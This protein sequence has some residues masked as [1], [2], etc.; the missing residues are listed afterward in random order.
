MTTKKIDTKQRAYRFTNIDGQTK[1]F[2]NLSQ[3][4]RELF[5][6]QK[7]QNIYQLLFRNGAEM[8][9]FEN[10]KIEVIDLDTLFHKNDGEV[11]YAK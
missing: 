8:I 10:Y 7:Y 9:F 4:D 2:R 5:N 6:G 11:V 3:A 1:I